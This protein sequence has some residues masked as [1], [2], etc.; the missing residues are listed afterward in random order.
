M[1]IPIKIT[2]RYHITPI[3]MTSV[4]KVDNI[5]HCP[6]CGKISGGYIKWHSHFGK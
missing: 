1:E 4:T 3:R 5:K 6:R 2:K